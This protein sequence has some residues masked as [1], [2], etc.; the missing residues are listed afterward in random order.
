[1]HTCCLDVASWE[2]PMMFLVEGEH[3]CIA[4]SGLKQ[5]VWLRK[6]FAIDTIKATY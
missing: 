4:S 5:L 2:L 3:L 6:Q 1:M